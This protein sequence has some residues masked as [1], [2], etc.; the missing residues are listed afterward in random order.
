MDMLEQG[1]DNTSSHE[2]QEEE[3]V[4]ITEETPGVEQ[5]AVTIAN[6]QQAT[7]FTDQNIQD[8]FRTENS[9]G[10]VTYRVVQVNDQSL[11]GTDEGSGTVS[12]V[13][14][15]AFANAP[16]AVAQPHMNPC[17]IPRS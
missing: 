7:A 16:Q 11:E 12:V 8:Q 5:T 15:A 13:S 14:A 1:L 6:V 2:K 3:V 17:N 4:Q 10:Q 9:G